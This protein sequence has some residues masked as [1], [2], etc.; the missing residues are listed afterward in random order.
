VRPVAEGSPVAWG[1]SVVA[2]GDQTYVFGVL[3]AT[4]E[5]YLARAARDH[6]ADGA[7]EFWAPSGWSSDPAAAAPIL[8]GLSD[9]LSV[10][11]DAAGWALVSQR[12]GFSPEIAAWRAPA[13]QG[14]WIGGLTIATVPVPPGAVSYNAVLHPELGRDGGLLLSSNLA[15]ADPADLGARPE[16]YRATWIRLTIPAS[17]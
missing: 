2:D 9:Q 7:W 5:L 11:R 16:L 12:P 13:P 14:P 4:K 1:A 15:P 17:L 6:V 8:A 10:I 3:D